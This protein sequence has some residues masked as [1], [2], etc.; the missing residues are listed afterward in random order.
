MSTPPN[1]VRDFAVRQREVQRKLQILQHAEGIGHVART[2]RYFG[3]GRANYYRWKRAYERYGEDGLVNAKTIP[4][5]PPNQTPPEVAEKVLHLRRKYHL[6]PE[7]NMWYQARYHGI[8]LSDDGHLNDQ[9]YQ[10]AHRPMV[11]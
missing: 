4:K 11:L 10:L 7:R 6:G 8:K 2:C 5:N 1:E 9:R 3:I